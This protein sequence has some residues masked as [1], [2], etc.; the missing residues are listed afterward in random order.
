M[1]FGFGYTSK[2]HT[3]KPKKL[4][5]IPKTHTQKPNF[6]GFIPKTQTQKTQKILVLGFGYKP[7]ILGFWV[8]VLGVYPNPNP[9]FFGCECMDPGLFGDTG[10][11]VVVNRLVFTI[12]QEFFYWE[13]L[14]EPFWPSQ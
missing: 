9:F 11:Y 4:G 8:W 6:F 13:S 1:G 7:K 10:K 2:T 3:Q 14:F 5:F 12:W